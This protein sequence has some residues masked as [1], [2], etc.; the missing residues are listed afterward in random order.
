MQNS[1]GI[2]VK[3]CCASCRFKD[4]TRLMTSRYCVKHHKRV[5]PAGWCEQWALSEQ[6]EAAGSSGGKVKC[7]AYLKY[8]LEVRSEESLANQQGFR[9][10]QKTIDQIR[11]EFEKNNG[12]IYME[13]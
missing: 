2:E 6:L 7:K 5:K 1:H 3:A 9:K 13:P 11:Q 12:S 8:V 4:L 10:P